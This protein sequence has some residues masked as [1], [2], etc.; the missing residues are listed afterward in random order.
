MMKLLF[1][2]VFISALSQEYAPND[3]QMREF[4]QTLSYLNSGDT[5]QAITSARFSVN[6]D[7]KTETGI[8]AKK[9]YDQLLPTVQKR[10][11]RE[12]RG[13]WNLFKKGSNWGYTTTIGDQIQKVLIIDENH[14][15]FYDL[16]NITKEKIL[17]KKEKIRF[18]EFENS[19]GFNF[20]FVFSD[21]SIW[22]FRVSERNGVL[23]QSNTGT[24]LIGSRTEIVCGNEELYYLKK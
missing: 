9:I 4:A 20:D 15:Y 10:L 5:I 12:M 8:A 14:F 2:F 21:S 3:D 19:M 17:I 24:E 22:S 11:M 1:L 6:W 23:K 13:T 16:D 18:T 7:T